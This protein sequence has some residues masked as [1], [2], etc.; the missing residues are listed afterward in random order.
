MSKLSIH[1]LRDVSETLL[2]P[3][4][5]LALES[6]RA[7]TLLTDHK[8]AE[9]VEQIDYDSGKLWIQPFDRVRALMR[10]QE[11]DRCTRAFLETYA[12]DIVVNIGCGLDTR[13]HRV[14]RRI[15]DLV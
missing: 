12:A 6:R 9:V 10:T 13:F 8:A 4:Y 7:D 11:L 14:D 15:C 3:L 2:L 1:D 5:F